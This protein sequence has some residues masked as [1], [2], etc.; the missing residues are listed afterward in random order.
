MSQQA[1]N[2]FDIRSACDGNSLCLVPKIMRTGIRSA[3]T[4]YN[5]LELSIERND[6]VVPSILICENEIVR[7]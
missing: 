5:T 1:L 4:G 6:Y 3:Y 7:V 2:A